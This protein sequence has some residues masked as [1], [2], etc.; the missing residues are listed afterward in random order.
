MPTEKNNA[1]M[2]RDALRKRLRTYFRQVLKPLGFESNSTRQR[3]TRTTKT[4][5]QS[6][7]FF[8]PSSWEVCIQCWYQYIPC[9]DCWEGLSQDAQTLQTFEHFKEAWVDFYKNAIAHLEINES[10]DIPTTID[11]IDDLL[12]KIDGLV[13][14]AV[15]PFFDKYQESSDVLSE[16]NAGIIGNDYINDTR[17]QWFFF[18]LALLRFQEQKFT[19]SLDLFQ[20]CLVEFRERE[21]F[22]KPRNPELCERITTPFADG[23]ELA[24]ELLK[25]RLGENS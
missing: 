2:V 12:V 20:K 22:L 4:L 7:H 3:W 19:E 11:G 14:Q 1:Q 24:V 21:E 9:F 23:V 8:M 10:C 18:N 15:L 5:R 13:N 25:K 16:Y 17:G 6:C